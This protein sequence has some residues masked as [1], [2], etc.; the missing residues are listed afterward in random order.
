MF[1]RVFVNSYCYSLGQGLPSCILIYHRCTRVENPGE[2]V[3]DV[4]AKIPRG[5]VKGFRKNF[6]GGSTY[7]AFYCIFINK[8]F[9]NLPGGVLFHTPPPPPYP[10]PVCI[11]VIYFSLEGSFLAKK[12]FDRSNFLAKKGCSKEVAIIMPERK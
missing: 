1:C 11:Y 10:P 2:G 6:Q 8:F 9:E 7:F 12:F 3:R 5:G 4:F